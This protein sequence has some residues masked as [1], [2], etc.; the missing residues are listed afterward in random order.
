[1]EY[2]VTMIC[3]E[4]WRAKAI[5]N[6]ENPDLEAVK[7]EAWSKFDDLKSG[8]LEQENFTKVEVLNG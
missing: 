8:S 6:T 3:R 5:V 4:I 7:D 2:E 1:M